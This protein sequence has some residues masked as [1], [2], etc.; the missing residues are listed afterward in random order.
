[1]EF[2]Y[3]SRKF[4]MVKIIGDFGHSQFP[5]KTLRRHKLGN[6]ALR[7][8]AGG[9]HPGQMTRPTVS[10]EM[11]PDADQDPTGG[12]F[13]FQGFSYSPTS[14]CAVITHLWVL[15]SQALTILRLIPVHLDWSKVSASA[16]TGG[17]NEG[18]TS[19]CAWL[20]TEAVSRPG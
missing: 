2:Y 18:A 5:E 20:G 6:D 13:A 15:H 14:G 12:S 16:S 1:M 19:T 10:P 8:R 4:E 3:F 11:K 7:S 9:S 17:A